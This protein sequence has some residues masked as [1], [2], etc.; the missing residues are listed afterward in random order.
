MP[1][2]GCPNYLPK[3]ADEKSG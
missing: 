2:N 1:H 3:L